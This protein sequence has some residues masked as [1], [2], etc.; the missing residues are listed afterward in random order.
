[1]HQICVLGPLAE[2]W[3]LFS[4]A[5]A[6]KRLVDDGHKSDKWSQIFL[7]FYYY[8]KI[9]FSILLLLFY[10]SNPTQPNPR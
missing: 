6:K 3:P 4:I 5:K 7:G 10:Y 1:M 9:F 2:I 8:S